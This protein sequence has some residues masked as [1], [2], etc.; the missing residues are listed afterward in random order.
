MERPVRIRLVSLVASLALLAA[1]CAFLWHV[2]PEGPHHQSGSVHCDL[3]LQLDRAV[4]PVAA[5]PAAVALAASWLAPAP[6][7]DRIVTLRRQHRP[8]LARAPPH[9]AST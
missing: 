1:T 7:P 2:H 5:A 6:L 8:Q 9:F 3:C 4:G